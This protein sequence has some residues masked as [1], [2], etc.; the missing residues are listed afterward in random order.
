MRVPTSASMTFTLTTMRPQITAVRCCAAPDL[1]TLVRPSAATEVWRPTTDDVDRISWGRPA[2]K[3]GTGSRG[4]PHRLNSD[5][6]VLYDLARRKGFL[7]MAGSGW[8][9]Q[10]SDAPL[11]NTYRSWCDAAAHACLVLHKGN[12]FDE[13]V[14]DLSPL[15]SPARFT[16]AATFCLSLPGAADGVIVEAGSLLASELPTGEVGAAGAAEDTAAVELSPEEVEAAEAAATA[17]GKEVSQLKSEGLGNK[18]PQVVAAV[19]ELLRLK[20][21]LP[22]P[23]AEGAENVEGVQSGAELAARD[24]AFA[25]EPIY[26]LPALAISWARPRSEAKA[27]ARQQVHTAGAT[28]ARSCPF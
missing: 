1:T 10:R 13:I 14:L 26:R 16:D 11:A 3:K 12:P 22:E 25:T 6:R 23:G 2:K 19:A 5:E 21:L 17:Q 7:E 24:D 9:K 20:A 4:V 8:R 27:L 15:R 18:D 28:L